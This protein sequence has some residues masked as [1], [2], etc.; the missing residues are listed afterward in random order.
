MISQGTDESGLGR[1]SWT[2]YYGKRNITLRVICAYRPCKL[3][4]PGANTV[5]AQHQRVFNISNENRCPRQAIL[6]DLQHKI[7]SWKE[8]NGDQIIL[9]MD[10]NEDLRSNHMNNWLRNCDLRNITD[11]ITSQHSPATQHR[12]NYPIDGIFIS[13]TIQPQRRGFLPF[14]EF[15][16]DHRAV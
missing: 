4:T 14:G 9:M 12:G 5:Y 7:I 10:C 6:Q 2:R 16:S 8:A 1:W 15:P 11:E 13:N 3:H